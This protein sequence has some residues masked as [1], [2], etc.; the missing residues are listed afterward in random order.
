MHR[1]HRLASTAVA[2]SVL[3]ALAVAVSF[4]ANSVEHRFHVNE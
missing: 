2:S 1:A 3:L 4:D